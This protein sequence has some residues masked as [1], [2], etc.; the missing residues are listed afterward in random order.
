MKRLLAAIGVIVVVLSAGLGLFLKWN[1]GGGAEFPDRRTSPQLSA[2]AVEVLVELPYPP[3]NVA[4]DNPERVFFSFH[5]EGRP[6]TNVALWEAGEW[7][8]WPGPQWQPGGEH[9]QAFHEVLSLRLDAP[10]RRLW[11]LD[12]GRHGLHAPRVMAFNADTGVL[13]QEHHFDA[14]LAGPGSHFNDFQISPDGQTLY[15]ADASFFAQTPALVVFE[16]GTQ[17]A[18]RLLESH[19]STRAER[20]VPVV[21]GR[22]MELFGLVSIRPGVDSIA[23]DPE[24]TWLYFASVTSN[25]LW[26]VRTQDLRNVELTA[27][28]LAAKVQRLGLKTMS[29]GILSPA[30]GQIVLTDPEHP[31]L[32]TIGPQQALQT[33]VEHPLLRWPDGLSMDNQGNLYITASGLHL[34]MGKSSRAISDQAPWHILRMSSESFASVSQ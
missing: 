30:M 34:F 26:R 20:Y 22:R 16:L 17:Q 7:R 10:R 8:P 2:D 18:R 5:P 12:T 21:A 19:A 9:P 28:Q 11:V 24:G 33:L 6:P 32:H 25:Y 1:Y 13:E 3:G 31:A 23:L 4:A 27:A 15:I 14:E 29:D